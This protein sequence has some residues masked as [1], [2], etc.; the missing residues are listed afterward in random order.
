M[1]VEY[2]R[3][4]YELGKAARGEKRHFN[5]SKLE[6]DFLRFSSYCPQRSIIARVPTL[7]QLHGDEQRHVA[8][9]C[10]VLGIQLAQL[11]EAIDIS[12]GIGIESA[13]DTLIFASSQQLQA[14]H[15]SNARSYL[16][17]LIE[18]IYAEGSALISS[19]GIHEALCGRVNYY[20]GELDLNDIGILPHKFSSGPYEMSVSLDTPNKTVAAFHSF[21]DKM[22]SLKENPKAF[23]LHPTKVEEI[24]HDSLSL[25]ARLGALSRY[26]IPET[27]DFAATTNS[28]ML[29]K[30]ETTLFYLYQPQKN[31][32]ILVYFGNS[33]FTA[34][35]APPEDLIILDGRAHEQTLAKLLDMDIFL[36]SASVLEQR[37]TDLTKVYES[38]AR[39]LQAPLNG[40]TDFM[41][42][43]SEL[44]KMKTYFTEVVNPALHKEEVLRQPAEI[45]ELMVCPAT[46]D[47][48][49]HELLPRLSWNTNLRK[50]HNTLR[51]IRDFGKLGDDEKKT[52]VRDLTANISF[53]NHQNNDVNLW[54]YKNYRDLCAQA[55][56]HFEV[57]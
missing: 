54:L 39:T 38:A 49:I 48:V 36:P 46:D 45:V 44:N 42:L 20:L 24:T 14:D 6:E 10:A 15:C 41:R 29:K 28:C 2:L 34:E 40:N 19:F 4:L 12:G 13:A 23:L 26:N 9:A 22:Q 16:N 31:R 3:M 50:Y 18:R 8:D 17:P 57:Q 56:A 33:P 7:Y 21:V 27:N 25:R 30:E 55:G 5:T 43:L 37:I 52:V 53:H 32:N 11:P 51:F 1:T 35:Q 47:P